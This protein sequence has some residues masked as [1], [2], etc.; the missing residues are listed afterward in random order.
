MAKVETLADEHH[1]LRHVAPARLRKDA[2][3]KVL[4]VFY[5]AFELRPGEDYLSAA[6]VEFFGLDDNAANVAAAITDFKKNLKVKPTH[7]FVR[8]NVGVIREACKAHSQRVRI[9]H[10]PVPNFDSHASVRQINTD[11]SELLEL[12]AEEAWAELQEI[13]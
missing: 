12:L 8:G 9:S 6:W 3:G 1:I 5:Q 13:V 10:E 11:G 7:R 4:G 2:A